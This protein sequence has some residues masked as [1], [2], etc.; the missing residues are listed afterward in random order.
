M[1]SPENQPEPQPT[2]KGRPTPKR[3]EAE[4][5][6]RRPLVPTDRK[7]ARRTAKEASRAQRDRE[8]QAMQSG[9]DRYMP[10]RDKGPIRRWVRDYIDARI[11]PGEFFLPLSIGLLMVMIL[12]QSNATVAFGAIAVLYAYMTVAI[13]DAAL[14]SRRLRKKLTAKFGVV[15][16]G[17][18]M[19]GIMRAFQIRQS[20]LPKPQVKRRQYPA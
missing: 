14:L 2:G 17:T 6:H 15:P 16:K 7:A 1:P 19:Y 18:L 8:F 9:D 5:A 20:R 3:K 11:S 10:A 12:A 13:V 4:A